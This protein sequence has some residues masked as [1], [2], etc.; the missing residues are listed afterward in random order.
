V[1]DGRQYSGMI[2]GVSL[3]LLYLIFQQ[4]SDWPY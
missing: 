1:I 3:P 4:C 2:S